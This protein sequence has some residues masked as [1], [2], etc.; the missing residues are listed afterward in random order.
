MTIIFSLFSF[1]D[2][3]RITGKIAWRDRHGFGVK[4]DKNLREMMKTA[5]A[6]PSAT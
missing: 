6:P 2:P 4:L 3:I 5:F 1:E